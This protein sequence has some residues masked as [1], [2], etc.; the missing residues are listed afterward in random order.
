MTLCSKRDWCQCASRFVTPNIQIQWQCVC[1]CVYTRCVYVS[2]VCV[3]DALQVSASDVIYIY[4]YTVWPRLSFV[5]FHFLSLFLFPS[6]FFVQFCLCNFLR[7]KIFLKV[8]FKTEKKKKTTYKKFPPTKNQK[9]KQ[10]FLKS[11]K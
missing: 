2:C 10:K 9:Q 3:C 5:C 1:V 4:I 7:K 11:K 8:F 6:F